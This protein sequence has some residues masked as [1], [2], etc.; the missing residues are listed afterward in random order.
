MNDVVAWLRLASTPRV[1]SVT[2][3]QLLDYYGNAS[4]ALANVGTLSQY[5][6]RS[7]PLTPPPVSVIEKILKQC[8]NQGIHV[9]CQ[10]EADYPAL[11]KQIY[12]A[13]P[14]LYIKGS[15]NLSQ[16]LTVGIVG[17]RNA[18][19]SGQLFTKQ[20][21]AA[22]GAQDI[23]VISGLARGIDTAAHNGSLK[24]GTMA[25]LGGG[26]DHIYP[27]ENK[28]LYASIAES[29]CLIS[30]HPPGMVPRAQ[31]FPRRNRI[32][33]GLSQAVVVIEAAKRSGSL[34]TARMAGEQGREVLA[35][36]GS[37]LDPRCHGSN[38]LIKNGAALVENVDDV[39]AVLHSPMQ[40]PAFYPTLKENDSP[41]HSAFQ[42]SDTETE[43]WRNKITGAL[44]PTPISKTD[45]QSITAAPA[46][47]MHLVLLE[48]QLAER[49]E[50]HPGDKVSL[51]C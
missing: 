1:G 27:P 24:T 19:A 10:F 23:T 30:E 51:I 9:L 40:Q 31:H 47:I 29:G 20:L 7:K 13:P 5:G 36:P 46:N 49:L 39:L 50:Y 42:Y 4:E 28:S 2:F 37:P 34:I 14:I 15:I 44:C 18:S 12:D 38:G 17:S 6:G 33:A 48:L 43:N 3:K 35:V 26:I 8:S 21:A 45:L 16:H 32:I 22:L 25:V 11:L 41:Y